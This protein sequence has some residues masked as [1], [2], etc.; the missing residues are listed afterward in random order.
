MCS[1]YIVTLYVSANSAFML[2]LCRRQ[3]WNLERSL[4][5]LPDIFVGY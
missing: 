5:K 1:I 3:Q 4:C 2:I